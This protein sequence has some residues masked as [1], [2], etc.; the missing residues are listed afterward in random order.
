MAPS[1]FQSNPSA[2][3]S[4]VR[5][6]NGDDNDD[7]A[8][9][10]RAID[11]MVRRVKKVDYDHDI[12]Y[13]AGY[14]ND[15][16]TVFIDRHLPRTFRYQ[17][18]SVAVERYLIVHEEVEKTLIDRLGLDYLHA[19][20]IATRAEKAAVCAAHISWQSYDRFMQHYVRVMHDKPLSR[21]PADLDLTPYREEH[22]TELMA[23]M[24][25]AIRA[26]SL[27]DARDSSASTRSEL[28]AIGVS[29]ALATD[30]SGNTVSIRN[31]TLEDM[32]A[33]L[34]LERQ[35]FAGDR[36]SRAQYRRYLS[37]APACVHIATIE[38]EIVGVI[39]ALFRRGS[40]CVRL[41]SMATSPQTRGQGI[42][43][44]LM[45][46]VEVVARARQATCLRFEVRTDN[47]DAIRWYERLGY[48]PFGRYNAY[49]EDGADALRY[50]KR[51]G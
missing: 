7:D 11:A 41:Y 25:E 19:H 3:R 44:A 12:P 45:A 16:Q 50:E 37:C 51:I 47:L 13:V 15:G 20:E 30:A 35:S 38:R 39:I 43:N 22:D 5:I 24:K 36:I 27:K 10:D 29:G 33:L 49:Y 23:R 40:Q 17:G 46:H 2:A 34:E 42:G 1:A 9:L 18:R 26:S 48:Q 6:A 21:I 28:L 8:M 31:G 32:E 4:T 14:S